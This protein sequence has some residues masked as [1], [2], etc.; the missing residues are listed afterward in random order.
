MHTYVIIVGGG[1]IGARLA[2]RL[3]EQGADVVVIEKDEDRAH[4]LAA[5]LD[6]LVIHGSGAEL[7]V[8]KDAGVGKADILVAIAQADEVNLMACELAKKMGVKKVI[9]RVNEE[10]HVKMFEELGVD[11]AIS[12][13]VI[14]SQIF[15]RAIKGPSI[16]GLFEVGRGKGEA[17][18]VTVGPKSKAT[19]K[20]VVDLPIP[21]NCTLA[22]VVRGD[23][24]IPPKGSTEIFA[25][26]LVTLVGK[27]GDVKKLAKYLRGE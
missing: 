16:L 19:G 14:A 12:L 9:A 4:R 5:E 6:A 21:K 2:S 26:D 15:E 22:M 20:K 17:A 8:L 18:E 1:E 10:D 13:P 25:G 23:T 27:H 3:S 7:D 24:V 11:M